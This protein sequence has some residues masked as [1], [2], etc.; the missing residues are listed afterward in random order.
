MGRDKKV[1][2]G[3]LQFVLLRAIGDA[4]VSEAPQA[5]AEAVLTRTAAHA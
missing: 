4:Y 5:D 1:E 3:K 2:G